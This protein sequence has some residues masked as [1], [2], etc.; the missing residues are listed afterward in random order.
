MRVWELN[1][2]LKLTT[3]DIFDVVCQEYHLNANLIEKE[4]NCKCSF[5]LTGFLSELEPLELS[6]Y[7]KI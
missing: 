3:E 6:Y 2:N 5:A 7:L 1:E 4:L